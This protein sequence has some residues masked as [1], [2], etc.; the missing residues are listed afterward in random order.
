M[1]GGALLTVRDQGPGLA[2]GVAAA[3]F[4]PHISS[5]A[6]GAGMGLYLCQRLLQRYYR[7]SVELHPAAN[8]GCIATL[9]LCSANGGATH[10]DQTPGA[11]R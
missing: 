5:K 8:G 7:G 10:T 9:H 1:Q 2:A 3:L 6:E 4:Q 11:T